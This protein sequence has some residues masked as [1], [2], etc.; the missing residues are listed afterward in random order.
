MAAL[1]SITHHRLQTARELHN[2][3][4]SGSSSPVVCLQSMVTRAV[5]QSATYSTHL[6]GLLLINRH[7]L[8]VGSVYA[9]V[10]NNLISHAL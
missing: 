5:P 9:A 10:E 6:V 7:G 2:R 3:S 4:V 1:M 8:V